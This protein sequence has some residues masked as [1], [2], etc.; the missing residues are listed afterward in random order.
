M[1]C[2][3][4]DFVQRYVYYFGVWEPNLSAFISRSVQSGDTFVD[5]GANVGYFTLLAAHIV[6]DT[7]SVIALEPEPRIRALMQRNLDL[8]RVASVRVVA[9][10]A[11]DQDRN[12]VVEFAG[13]HDMGRTQTRAAEAAASG[14]TIRGRALHDLMHPVERER[15]RLVKID[16]EGAELDAL[17]GMHLE[18]EDYRKDM[19]IVVEVA[20]NRL[21]ERGQSAAAL[22]AEMADYGYHAYALANDYRARAYLHRSRIE[23]PRRIRAPLREQTDVVFSRREA[24]VL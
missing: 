16:V 6:G 13:E 8:N 5:V 14:I 23:V 12:L 24:D 17:R 3:T 9:E 21:H 11:T 15:V 22:L 10:A 7:G 2:D 19:E 20:P 1:H 4:E 18:R